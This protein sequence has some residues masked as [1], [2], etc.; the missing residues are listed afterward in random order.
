MFEACPKCGK[1]KNKLLKC[2]HCGFQHSKRE[3]PYRK[4]Y[5]S[6]AASKDTGS[7]EER[8]KPVKSKKNRGKTGLSYTKQE[9]M[10]EIKRLE[11]LLAS[12]HATDIYKSRRRLRTLKIEYT[13]RISGY[14]RPPR[15]VSGGGTGLKR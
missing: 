15:I 8:G 7:Y 12:R 2:S 10:R 6:G 5:A 9:L 13:H 3:A 4:K 11:S 1:K 14:R